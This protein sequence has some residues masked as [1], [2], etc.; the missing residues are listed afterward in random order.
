[1]AQVVAAS[2]LSGCSD[3]AVSRGLCQAGHQRVETRR[4]E[5]LWWHTS[6]TYDI[7]VW[8]CDRWEHAPVESAGC[9]EFPNLPQGR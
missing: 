2:M 8:R 1:M 4:Q 3:C 7:T 6:Y 9:S 5:N